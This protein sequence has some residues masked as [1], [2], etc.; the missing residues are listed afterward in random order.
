MA[1]LKGAVSRKQSKD[2]RE[3]AVR[4]PW[5]L[6]QQPSNVAVLPALSCW[7]ILSMIR[8]PVLER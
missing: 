2:G 7:Q 6:L 5:G 8:V 1:A 3:A 4:G